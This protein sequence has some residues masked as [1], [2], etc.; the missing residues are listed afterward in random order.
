MSAVLLFALALG[1]A[2]ATVHAMARQRLLALSRRVFVPAAPAARRGFPP[3]STP[4]PA[5]GAHALLPRR[6]PP[7]PAP[8]PEMKGPHTQA[9]KQCGGAA[10]ADETTS[11]SPEGGEWHDGWTPVLPYSHTAVVASTRAALDV[12]ATA[13]AAPVNDVATADDGVLSVDAV[14]VAEPGPE[15]LHGRPELN[16]GTLSARNPDRGS[17]TV[18]TAS[19][20]SVSPCGQTARR[21]DSGSDECDEDGFHVVA[22]GG[23]GQ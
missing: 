1:A 19:A 15:P 14:V 16:A 20:P 17:D 4:A 10:S 22:P 3:T 13:T 6:E 5:A 21:G 2:Y 12:A 11:K 23:P 9:P 18:T 8:R 7:E